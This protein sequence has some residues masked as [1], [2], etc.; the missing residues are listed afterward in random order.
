[1]KELNDIQ[2]L[3]EP[4]AAS[5]GQRQLNVL[6]QPE[7]ALAVLDGRAGFGTAMVK[8]RLNGTDYFAISAPGNPLDGTKPGRVYVVAARTIQAWAENRQ[9]ANQPLILTDSNSLIIEQ[10][11]GGLF[12]STLAAADLNSD[13]GN[14]NITDEL[15]IGSPDPPASS[16]STARRCS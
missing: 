13:K 11:A 9:T 14:K 5:Q 2:S 10:M 6:I 8:L 15:I 7:P 16:S 3:D 1:M 4:V 12:G